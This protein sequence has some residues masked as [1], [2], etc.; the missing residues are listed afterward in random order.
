MRVRFQTCTVSLRKSESREVEL[1][2]DSKIGQIM[3]YFWPKI[4]NHR[5]QKTICCILRATVTIS[6]KRF[7]SLV[8]SLNG[9]SKHFDQSFRTRNEI[10]SGGIRLT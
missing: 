7:T 10:L 9:L 4:V 3:M 2:T 5:A 1:A 6:P 8:S